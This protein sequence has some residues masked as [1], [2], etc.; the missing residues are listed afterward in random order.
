M[1]RRRICAAALWKVLIQSSVACRAEHA[2]ETLS[3]LARG[4]VGEGERQDR[5]W[6]RPVRDQRRDAR[7]DDARLAAASAGEHQQR[8]LAVHHRFPL[9]LVQLDRHLRLLRCPCWNGTS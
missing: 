9:P 5:A 3:H 8:A 1:W 7:R 6:R 2:G 4:F